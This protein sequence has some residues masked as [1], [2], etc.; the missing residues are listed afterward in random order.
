MQT[1]CYG[2]WDLVPSQKLNLDSLHWEL[3]IFSIGPPV[4]SLENF[5]PSLLARDNFTDV[6]TLWTGTDVVKKKKSNLFFP[7]HNDSLSN[8]PQRC[9][10]LISGTHKYV[11]LYSNRNFANVTKLMILRWEDHSDYLG[12]LR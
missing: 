2:M 1:L 10:I 4:K 3:G 9:P 8:G 11:T 5:W 6:C 12:G 7:V